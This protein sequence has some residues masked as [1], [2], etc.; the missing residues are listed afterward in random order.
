MMEGAR[1]CGAAGRIAGM[2]D[3]GA[4]GASFAGLGGGAGRLGAFGLGELAGLPELDE[5]FETAE[6]AGEDGG[7]GGVDDGGYP[8]GFRV[9]FHRGVQAG[10]PGRQGGG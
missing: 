6:D 2:R 7:D 5:L 4:R 1:D 8:G 3:L 9:C 10:E